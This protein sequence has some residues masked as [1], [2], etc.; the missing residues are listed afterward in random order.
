MSVTA[1]SRM[2]R[3][4]GQGR[5]WRTVS[6]YSNLC[7]PV[8]ALPVNRYQ[9]HSLIV[10]IT[11]HVPSVALPVYRYL[12]HSFIVSITV[13]VPSVALPVNR[14]QRHS[15]I[16]SITVHVPSVALPVARYQRHS[17]IVSITV[18]V[19]SVALPV[20][21]YLRHSFIVSITVH[22]PSVAL[23]VARYQRHCG[24]SQRQPLS[25]L[26]VQDGKRKVR[27]GKCG[28]CGGVVALWH[29]SPQQPTSS[30]TLNMGVQQ[31]TARCEPLR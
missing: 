18:H 7:I 16:V 31:G 12:R 20:N 25:K 23:P 22:V 1:L 24:R 28:L 9:R 5:V 13:H 17:F 30:S 15:F 11:V 3:W 21:R 26:D 4:H 14:Y 8:L 27:T 10:S 29:Q 2:R 19:P 6:D